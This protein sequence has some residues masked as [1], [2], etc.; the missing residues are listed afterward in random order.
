MQNTI[1]TLKEGGRISLEEALELAEKCDVHT[2]GELGGLA[3]KAR[4]GNTAY[5]VYNQHMNY[6]DICANACR[7]CAF[8]KR[9][10]DETGFTFTVE[11]A[12]AKI[13][14]R[15]HEPIREVHIVGG[16]NP[17][18]PYEYY[19]ELIAGV[20]AERPEATVK[21]FTAV[22]VAYLAEL[23]G[24]SYQQVLQDMRDAGLGALPGGGAEV[25]SPALREK[26]CPEKVP[27]SVW[28]EIHELAHTMG[29]KTNCT[30]LFGHIETWRDRLEH[31]AALRDLQD[32]TNGFICFIPLQYQPGNNPLEA[33]GTDGVDYLKMIALSRLFLDNV[34]HLKAYWAFS[35]VKPA[36][37]AL[38]AGADDFDGTLVEE[39]VGHAAGASSPKGMT[40]TKL[41]ETIKQ[42][43]FTPVERDTFFN[44]I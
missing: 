10:G 16:L 5:Y 30:L 44:E 1:D 41:R 8:S 34:P 2:L 9:V 35:G 20:K 36:Q 19:L 42:S 24:I 3:R 29:I 4:Y 33:Q 17:A 21:A 12:Q 25:F 13:R 22:E 14:E 26:L 38:H 43:G 27:G 32:R 6:T 18:L 23:K 39:K 31:M 28:L 15:A 7:F 37:L 40:V 11:Q